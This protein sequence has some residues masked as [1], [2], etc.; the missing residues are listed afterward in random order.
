[1]YN[2]NTQPC[3]E[4]NPTIAF[5]WNDCKDNVL[6][7]FVNPYHSVTFHKIFW[8]C[9]TWTDTL[10]TE[11]LFDKSVTQKYCHVFIIHQVR[12]LNLDLL[13]TKEEKTIAYNVTHEHCR[14]LIAPKI[15]T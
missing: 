15:L 11:L 9:L 14:Q 10:H 3:Y 4:Q 1:M 5:T 12:V 6:N 13:T 7:N 2:S 8:R